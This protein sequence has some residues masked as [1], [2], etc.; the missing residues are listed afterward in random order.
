MLENSY[1]YPISHVGRGPR[2]YSAGRLIGAWV[3]AAG[4]ADPTSQPPIHPSESAAR[5]KN[6]PAEQ[7]P[8]CSLC[9]S[10]LIEFKKWTMTV[11][12]RFGHPIA[13][14]L[15]HWE[16]CFKRGD[17]FLNAKV[18]KAFFAK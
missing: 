4:L 13:C 15:L 1:P 7:A 12:H 6:Q 10:Y 16:A 9:E 5:L 18:K 17:M 14:E 11:V 2:A 3:R 8:S